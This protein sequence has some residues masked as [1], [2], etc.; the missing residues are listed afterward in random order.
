MS[1]RRTKN[2][3]KTPTNPGLEPD[4]HSAV[5]RLLDRLGMTGVVIF[6]HNR[7]DDTWVARAH[8]PGLGRVASTPCAT[9][10]DAVLNLYTKGWMRFELSGVMIAS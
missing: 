6:S 9:R 4:E 5:R 7:E 1:H 3:I 8:V 2:P 10:R